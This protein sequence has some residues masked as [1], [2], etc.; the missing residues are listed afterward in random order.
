MRKYEA[1]SGVQDSQAGAFCRQNS[2]N[3]VSLPTKILGK[4][5]LEF[6]EKLALWITCF[7]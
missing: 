5:A 4:V 3:K 6:T 7:R 1:M 2:K